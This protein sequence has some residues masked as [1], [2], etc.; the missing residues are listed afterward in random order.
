MQIANDSLLSDT[1]DLYLYISTRV[2]SDT[3]IEVS[4]R[5]LLNVFFDGDCVSESLSVK[6]ATT[7]LRPNLSFS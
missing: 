2:L 7:V 1:S 6:A 5:E 3:V 4:R